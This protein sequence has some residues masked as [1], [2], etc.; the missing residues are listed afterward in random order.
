MGFIEFP[1]LLFFFRR[2]RKTPDKYFCSYESKSNYTYQ[3][4][5]EG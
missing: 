2:K 5:Y 4:C 3:G 1:R